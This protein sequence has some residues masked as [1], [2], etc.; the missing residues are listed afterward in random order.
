MSTTNVSPVEGSFYVLDDFIM[1][2]DNDYHLPSVGTLKF[3]SNAKPAPNRRRTAHY[4]RHALNDPVVVAKIKVGL[5]SVPWIHPA[6]DTSSGLHIVT[7]AVQKVLADAA[8]KKEMEMPYA[9]QIAST[10]I[11]SDFLENMQKILSN[12]YLN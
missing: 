6:V 3:E 11:R 2:H 12:M 7:S 10:S 4:D 8:P 9:P 1:G 5:C